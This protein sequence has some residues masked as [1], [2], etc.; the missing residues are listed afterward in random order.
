MITISVLSDFMIVLYK[1]YEKSK[2]STGGRP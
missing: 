1:I 2:I